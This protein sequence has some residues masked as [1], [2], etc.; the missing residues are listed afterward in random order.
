METIEE[1]TNERKKV[2][3][4]QCG[5]SLGIVDTNKDHVPSQCLLLRPLP[6]NLPQVEICT[7]CN[8][9]FSVDE[10]YLFL[11]LNCVLSGSTDPARQ[12][13]ERVARALLRH[14]KLQARIE[15]SKSVCQAGGQ[16]GRWIWQPET[17]RI[18]SV[19]IKNARGH[20]FYEYGEP[21]LTEPQHVWAAPFEKM[22]AAERVA[23]ENAVTS[24]AFS[25]WPEVGTRMMAR[26]LTGQDLLDGWV[27]VQDDVY[28][29]S[30][31]QCDGIL[32]R[33]VLFEYLAT[34]VYWSNY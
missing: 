34:E 1:F 22:T 19:V 9:R 32:V 10:E 5:A 14:R 8:S 30:V 20:A 29:Y 13:D 27:V 12:T 16:N 2:S 18:E 4:I 3:C 11:F 23:F 21:V 17:D 15:G 7:S 26:V 24:G 31:E 33:S 6:E 25:P 28:R